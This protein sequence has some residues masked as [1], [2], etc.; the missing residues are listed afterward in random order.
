MGHTILVR[1]TKRPA[2]R[3]AGA[4]SRNADAAASQSRRTYC[5]AARLNPTTSW[6]HQHH[7]PY[8]CACRDGV[9]VRAVR[10]YVCVC[11]YVCMHVLV[12]FP[13]CHFVRLS[14]WDGDA[15]GGR[16]GRRALWCAG[17]RGATGRPCA[18]LAAPG[19][20][21]AAER[22]PG[23]ST[24]PSIADA[25]HTSKSECVSV[26]VS[27]SVSVC[28]CMYVYIYA[29]CVS[30]C[31]CVCEIERE[32]HAYDQATGTGGLVPLCARVRG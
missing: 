8:Q 28:T 6:G 4:A 17:C 19:A 13:R 23:T 11:V 30:E 26:C 21:A 9:C 12:L 2:L 14:V 5:S 18:P 29:S 22:V 20:I 31:V 27:Q 3:S 32:R 1:L 15:R 16:R 24:R 10:M 25:P 7:T